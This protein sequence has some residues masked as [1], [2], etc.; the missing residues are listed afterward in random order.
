MA[1]YIEKKIFKELLEQHGFK[2]NEYSTGG[3]KYISIGGK[4]RNM[5]FGLTYM[6]A[7]F[8]N[9]DYQQFLA[10][11]EQ[12]YAEYNRSAFTR[13]DVFTDEIMEIIRKDFL[14]AIRAHKIDKL[15]K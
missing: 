7:E 13:S 8:K 5:Y 3:D 9:F 6:S 11:F 12:K 2:L 1:V 10:T 14:A 15:S 4:G